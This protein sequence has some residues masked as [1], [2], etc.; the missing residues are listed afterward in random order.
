MENVPGSFG[1][2][3]SFALRFGQ[4][5][6]SAASLIFM[7]FDYDFYDFT[8]FCYLATVMAIVTPWSILLALTDT[9]SV[10]VKL[11][12]QELRVLS[13]VFAGDFVLS[14]LS[15]GGA[16]AVASATELLASADGKICDGNLCIQY[17]VSAALAFLCWFL[18]LASALFNFWSL[19][20]LYY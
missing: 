1:T 14:F 5:I 19:P 7:C 17:Q 10:L 6:F 11:L 18:L 13:I 12:P 15:L 3:A 8:T 2:S 20:S 9:Y 4:T 16:C